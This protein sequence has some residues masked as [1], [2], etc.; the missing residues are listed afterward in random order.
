M[1]DQM[2]A[3]IGWSFEAAFCQIT[4]EGKKDP[5]TLLS[6][7]EPV[8]AWAAGHAIVDNIYHD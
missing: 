6:L 2:T 1:N 4:N 3:A 5:W 7:K 8:N